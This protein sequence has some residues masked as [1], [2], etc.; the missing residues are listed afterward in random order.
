MRRLIY[1][2]AL[3]SALPL[4]ISLQSCKKDEETANKATV[5]MG[6]AVIKGRVTADLTLGNAQKEGV[7]GIK[8]TG[9]ISTADLVTNV[10]GGVTYATRTYEAITDNDGNYTLTVDANTKTVAVTYD[11]PMVFN[12]TQTVENGTTRN[13]TFTRNNTYPYAALINIS[14][15][16]TYTQNV[17]YDYGVFNNTAKA[18]LMGEVMF[19]N[20]RCTSNNPD[21]QLNVVP[22]N[23]KV[24]ATWMDDNNNAREA[25]L[26]VV[27]GKFT[28]AV[29]TSNANK[30]ITVRGVKFVST[31]KSKNPSDSCITEVN[32]E[33]TFGTTPVSINKNETE[34]RKYTFN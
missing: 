21:S 5:S 4:V 8:V 32:H 27:N 18:T 29:E 23:T 30:M 26:D 20:D 25:Y 3:L 24:L 16:Q 12:A 10:S 7:A 9:R 17:E 28:F 15:G 33:Y 19:R 22:A 34:T 6:S 13:T 2:V 31:Y 14:R 11:A 1:K